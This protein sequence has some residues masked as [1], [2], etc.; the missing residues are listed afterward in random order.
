MYARINGADLFFDVE[1]S[2]YVP[3]GA[4]ML[5]KPTCFVLH[6]G[7]GSDHSYFKPWLTPLSE[8]MQLVYVDHRG[9]GQSERTGPATYKIEQMADDLEGLRR[10]LGLG[11]VVV[12]GNSFGGMVAQVYAT[13]HPE[14]VEKL[15]LCTTA[16]SADFWDEAQAMAERMAT[17]EQKEVLTD[18][19]EG[20]I[21][22]EDELEQW[23]RTCLPLYFHNKDE[24]I[25]EAF[26]GRVTARLEVANY[27]MANEIPDYD[28]RRGL[29]QVEAE[30]LVIA[31]RHD[32]VTPV[33]QS[34]AIHDLLPNSRMVVYEDS[35]HMPFI[36]EQ[37]EFNREV[38]DFVF[39]GARAEAV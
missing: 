26:L 24:G 38:I 36:E 16:P 34:Q 28:V 30:T 7:P 23:W 22:D 29:P 1:G 10:H 27:M 25:M 2:G 14:S 15:V 11:R 20:R 37:E 21:K 18:L 5:S 6:G 3:S 17:P 12:F 19:F 13:R 33:S 8:S 31:G 35:G 39:G 9:N 4:Q 32:W